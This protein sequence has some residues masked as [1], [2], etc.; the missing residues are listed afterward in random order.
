M[1]D[2]AYAALRIPLDPRNVSTARR[3]VHDTCVAWTAPVE[4]CE[5]A[6]TVVSELVTNAFTHGR[7]DVE[8]CLREHGERL[9]VEV[10]D[11]D[12]RLPAPGPPDD[13]ALGGRGLS[14]VSAVADA[15]GAERLSTGK[16]VWAEMSWQ[17]A[18]KKA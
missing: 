6:M 17:D 15:W 7:S 14:L 12:S 11:E 9:R 18:A 10:R 13:D 3:F 8:L 16:C 2:H 4:L 5:N 1:T